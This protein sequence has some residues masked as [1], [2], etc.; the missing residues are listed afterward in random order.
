M[1]RLIT[2]SL[3]GLRIEADKLHFNPRPPKNWPSYKMHYR[4]RN[5]FY[6]I[7]VNAPVTPLL[8]AGAGNG[9]GIQSLSI[10]GVAQSEHFL[11]LVDDQIHHQVDIQLGD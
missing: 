3:L 6:H 9:D 5:T 1:Y 4:Y 8:G 10:D 7:T 11:K 2:E